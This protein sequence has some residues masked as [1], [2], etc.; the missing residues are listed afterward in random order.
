MRAVLAEQK[1]EEKQAKDA[2]GAEGMETEDKAPA[3]AERTRDR[4]RGRTKERA[5]S[6]APSSSSSAASRS[7]SRK[8]LR[9]VSV[10]RAA[11]TLSKKMLFKKV[12]LGKKKKSQLLF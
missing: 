2:A 7:R 5:E 8:P 10:A 3:A 9:N 4:S 12:S 6:V 11:K 1:A